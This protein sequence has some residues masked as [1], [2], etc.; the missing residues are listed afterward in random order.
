M[1]EN[2]SFD[3]NE[4]KIIDIEHKDGLLEELELP[5]NVIKFIRE[6]SQRLQIAA[7]CIVVLILGWT[8]YDYH[9]QNVENKGSAAL[10]AAIM[11][12]DESSRV[13]L[14]KNVEKDFSGTEASFWS[15]VEQ[16]HIALKSE[17]YDGALAIYNDLLDDISTDNP[18]R[19]LLNY[20]IG[21]TYENSGDKDNA[22]R[23]YSKL[24][25]FEGF[26]V[27]GL[28]S[29]G[30]IHELNNNNTEALRLY[31]QALEDES[32][33]SQDKLLLQEKVDSLQAGQVEKS[34]EG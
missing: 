4:E 17:D 2:N 12:E 6:N 23:H 3:E 30:R 18:I 28:I 20:N 34:T 13:E 11:E 26:N 5:P 15:R 29:Q 8:Y 27:K 25:G 19:P 16:G 33:A 21:L 14:L 10:N 1:T 24:S 31:R 22:L 32:I 9:V 7:A